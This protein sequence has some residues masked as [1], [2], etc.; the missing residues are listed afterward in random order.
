MSVCFVD[1]ELSYCNSAFSSQRREPVRYNR[2]IS[3]VEMM[4]RLPTYKRIASNASMHSFKLLN[5]WRSTGNGE[6][7]LHI[8]NSV[9]LSLS[10]SAVALRE[11]KQMES[12]AIAMN[13]RFNKLEYNTWG[14]TETSMPYRKSTR[15]QHWQILMDKQAHMHAIHRIV[16]S[17][18]VT[19]N[20]FEIT[21]QKI[22]LQYSAPFSSL[23]VGESER[24]SRREHFEIKALW[25]E[26]W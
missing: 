22:T 26:R 19:K 4:I 25:I 13:E 2:P 11:H 8:G 17:E 5:M 10:T 9:A 15:Q 14:C 24:D 3:T 6:K 12:L 16:N 7:A 23:L 20:P 18:H 1:Y 21:E